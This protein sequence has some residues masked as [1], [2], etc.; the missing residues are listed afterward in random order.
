MVT[1]EQLKVG[2]LILPPARELQLWMRRHCQELGLSESALHLTIR[3]KYEGAPDKRGRWV[4]VKCDQT[5]EWNA[6]RQ[7][8]SFTFKARPETYW[9]T[10]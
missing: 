3:E 9:P 2:D 1:V 8:G 5:K 4:V 7:G 6:G 10:V